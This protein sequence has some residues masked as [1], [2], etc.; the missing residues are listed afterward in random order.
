MTARRFDAGPVEDAS[1]V[2]L[3]EDV[4][5][6]NALVIVGVPT[7]GLVGSITAQYLVERMEMPIVG[8]LRSTHF[9][10]TASIRDGLAWPPLRLHMIETSCGFDLGCERVAVFTGEMQPYPTLVHATAAALIRWCKDQGAAM[11]VLPDAFPADDE[12]GEQDGDQAKEGNNH[13]DVP[14]LG[15]ASTQR[16]LDFITKAGVEPL[17]GATIMGLTG[18]AL[19]E[20]R[21]HDLDAVGLLAPSS[22]DHPDAR[23]AARIVKVLD[24]V[25]PDVRIDA[26]PLLEQAS[27]IETMLRQLQ[28]QIQRE[29]PKDGPPGSPMFG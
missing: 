6:H 29:M 18:A 14:I 11:V 5:L 16:A 13:E 23:A 1:E 26:D 15:A 12:A 19:L 20:A 9:P 28:A 4:S 22:V 27:Q 17:N 10:P 2:V 7:L 25:I 24:K 8:G 3:F 21:I